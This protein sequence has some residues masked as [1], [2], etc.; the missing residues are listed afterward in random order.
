VVTILNDALAGTL[1]FDTEDVYVHPEKGK[2]VTIGV[3]RTS[4]S[5]GPVCCRYKTVD[6]TAMAGREYRETEGFVSF[7]DGETHQTIEV[8]LL[9]DQHEISKVSFQLILDDPS[10]GVKFDPD[11]AGRAKCDICEIYILGNLPKSRSQRAIE[12]LDRRL[13]FIHTLQEYCHQI[14]SIFYCNGCA[15][16]QADAGTVDWVMHAMTLPFKL[17]FSIVPPPCFW[18]GWACFWSAL[19]MIGFVTAIV[20]DIASLLGCCIGIPDEITAITLVALGTSLPDTFASKVAAQQNDTADDSIG[21][22]TGS[23]CVNVFLGLGMPWTFAAIYWSF[24]GRSS[25]WDKKLYNGETFADLYGA[26]Y[27]DGGFMVPAGTL[28][29]SVLVF[30]FCAGLCVVLLIVRR[31]IY[32]GELGGSRRSC[33]RDSSILCTLWVIYVAL[34]IWKCLETG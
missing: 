6:G 2:S 30:S 1:S 25:E 11:T 7:E 23:N 17:L 3:K 10:K 22:V 20:G 33:M 26:T 13:R 21:N 27:P 28:A 19:A 4:G 16:E 12:V 31:V 29:F 9:G 32:G 8:A 5:A 18:G 15:S 24:E 34:S 14:A